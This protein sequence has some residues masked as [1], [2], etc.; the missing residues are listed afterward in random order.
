MAGLSHS[1]YETAL[2]KAVRVLA[3]LLFNIF[4]AAMLLDAFHSND[5]GIDVHYKTEGGIFNLRRLAAKSKITELL[6]RDLLYADDCALA[7]H[8]L[9][10]AQTITDC[11]ARA[12]K[13][14]TLTLSIKKTEVLRQVQPSTSPEVSI[15]SLDTFHL[16]CLRQIAGIKWQDKIPNT[17][18]LERCK[19]TG[20]EVF[21]RQAQLRWSGHLVRMPDTRLPKAIFYS[22][23]SSLAAESVVVQ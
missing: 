13:H 12:A 19:M 22:Q 17:E 14:F 4:Y 21:L 5:P 11:F 8:S 3:P 10:D 7:A 9:E 20:I 15:H 6:A 2:S 16:R 18:V 23:L 1:R